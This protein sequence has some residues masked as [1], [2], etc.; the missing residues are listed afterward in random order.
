MADPLNTSLI[1]GATETHTRRR[2]DNLEDRV[3]QHIDAGYEAHAHT[4]KI[5]SAY[6]LPDSSTIINSK[7][8]QIGAVLNGG[9]VIVV[10]P[11]VP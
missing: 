5:N 2:L 4:V 8:L 6:V 7:Q 9:P 11:I 10:V 3:Q 1:T